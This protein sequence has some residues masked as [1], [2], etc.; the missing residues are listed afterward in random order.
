[1]AINF[2]NLN[3]VRESATQALVSVILKTF[4][5]PITQGAKDTYAEMSR[6]TSV[7]AAPGQEIENFDLT[8]MCAVTMNTL[9]GTSFGNN[10]LNSQG[11]NQMFLFGGSDGWSYNRWF[12]I[13]PEYGLIEMPYTL[14]FEFNRGLCHSGAPNQGSDL[15]EAKCAYYMVHSSLLTGLKFRF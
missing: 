6:K 12:T 14:P 5:S 9:H 3:D 10:T 7:P 4:L 8:S 11:E 1:M 2:P 13:H 15:I